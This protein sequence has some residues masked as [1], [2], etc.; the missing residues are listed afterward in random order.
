M[1]I[2]KFDMICRFKYPYQLICID[3]NF[4]KTFKYFPNLV[5]EGDILNCIGTKNVMGIGG[6]YNCYV[7]NTSE[8]T[9]YYYF[10]EWYINKYFEPIDP[11]I[12]KSIKLGTIPHSTLKLIPKNTEFYSVDFGETITVNRDLIIEIQKDEKKIGKVYGNMKEYTGHDNPLLMNKK[13]GY[14]KINYKN[15]IP[16][17]KPN[18]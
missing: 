8:S 18:I 17:K 14:I 5:K 16:F 12:K 3:D 6:D 1:N 9:S 7:L 4:E 10:D 13:N 2:N 15:L 11:K